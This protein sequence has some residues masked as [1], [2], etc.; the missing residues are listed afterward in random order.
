MMDS[1]VERFS[2]YAPLIVMARL[3]LQRALDPAWVDVVFERHRQSQYRR[4]LLFSTFV[5]IMSVVAVGLRPSVHAAAKR[6]L[7]LPVSV[8]AL[9]D[10]INRTEPEIVRALVQGSHDRLGAILRNM[11]PLP[12]PAVPGYRLRIVDGNHLPRAK[13]ASNHYERFV[14]QRCRATRWW[15]IT[16]TAIWW[17]T[18]C[19]ARM[20]MLRS[21]PA[22]GRF[23]T[24]PARES[25]G[26]PTVISAPG[27]F[28]AAGT[29]TAAPSS[30]VNMAALPTR[31]SI[32]KRKPSG[33]PIR[34][35]SSRSRSE[36][37]VN[38]RHGDTLQ[39]V[40]H[41]ILEIAEY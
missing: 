6:Y 21:V 24:R 39:E 4:E 32:H 14:V 13:N 16:R 8:T 27:P 3:T 1:I 10:K 34:A 30:C 37:K 5:E 12:A 33:A 18:C 17:R 20:R 41:V 31:P 22:W 26:S 11:G 19:R 38:Y 7:N 28:W 15:S 29:R 36:V 25:C 40:L 9:Y 2:Q 35:P 23:W